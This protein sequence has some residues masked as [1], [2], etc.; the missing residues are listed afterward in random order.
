MNYDLCDPSI[1][2]GA[3]KVGASVFLTY[4]GGRVCRVLAFSQSDAERL[5]QENL[6][7]ERP[8]AAEPSLFDG[9]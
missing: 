4:P 5:A 7:S 3:D 6:E 1:R 2:C 9:F 8:A